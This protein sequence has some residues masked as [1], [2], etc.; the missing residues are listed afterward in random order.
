MCAS[1]LALAESRY[2]FIDVDTFYLFLSCL[3]RVSAT[4]RNTSTAASYTYACI[5]KRK[6][7]GLDSREIA[8]LP[9]IK[10]VVYMERHFNH[11]RK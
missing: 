1:L 11:H 6:L 7:K 5:N 2:Y 8:S 10:Q 4:T 3:V 9:E